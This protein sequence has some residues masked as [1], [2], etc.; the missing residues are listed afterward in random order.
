MLSTLF[1]HDPHLAGRTIAEARTLLANLNDIE[2]RLG[3]HEEKP[4]DLGLAR[5]T[6]RRI[7]N[8]QVLLLVIRNHLPAA[9]PDI[10][11][12]CEVMPPRFDGPTASR[13]S[14]A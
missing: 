12:L 7:R 9:D 13:A 4:G 14:A 6:A 2:K 10:E 3:T 8:R 5:E 11:Y 1:E